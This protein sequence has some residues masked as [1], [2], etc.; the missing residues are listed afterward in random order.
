MSIN[1]IDNFSVNVSKPIDSRMVVANST[2]RNSITYK[3][4]G[5]KVFQQD[6]RKTYIWNSGT[7][8]WTIEN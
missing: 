5:M 3:Y 1:I 6:D 8:T 2:A 4:D 7:S